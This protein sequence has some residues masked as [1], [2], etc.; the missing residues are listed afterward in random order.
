MSKE[1]SIQKMIEAI[2]I[3]GYAQGYNHLIY[4]TSESSIEEGEIVDACAIGQAALNLGISDTALSEKLQMVMFSRNVKCVEGCTKINKNA[5]NL[6]V[7]LNDEHEF[8]LDKIAAILVDRLPKTVKNLS[9]PVTEGDW[10]N[11][12]YQGVKIS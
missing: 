1:I 3:G 9:F 7:H 10:R 5:W 11:T 4:T 6:I 8:G 2:K 12:N